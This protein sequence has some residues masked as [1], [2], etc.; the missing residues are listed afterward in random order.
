MDDIPMPKFK[1]QG[2]GFAGF[3]VPKYFG[4][5]ASKLCIWCT[6]FGKPKQTK[7]SAPIENA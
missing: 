3:D 4:R 1:C 5:P 7:A 6:K 2:C